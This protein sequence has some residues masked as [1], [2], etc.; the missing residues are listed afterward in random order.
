M[1]YPTLTV[2]DIRQYARTY[3]QELLCCPMME[4]EDSP[5]RLSPRGKR[6]LHEIRFRGTP[7]PEP[8]RPTKAQ[9]VTCSLQVKTVSADSGD[10]L[11]VL[12]YTVVA[13]QC[14]AT[15]G[16]SEPKD[17][18]GLVKTHPRFDLCFDDTLYVRGD[19]P[20]FEPW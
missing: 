14:S 8:G 2:N 15:V 11:Q 3:F 12:S 16:N 4:D 1:T 9:A 20:V 7:Q 13:F 17:L 6:G 18:F 10:V 5:K 19:L